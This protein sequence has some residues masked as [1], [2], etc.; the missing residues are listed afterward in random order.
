MKLVNSHILIGKL[1]EKY[2]RTTPKKVLYRPM[3]R[4]IIKYG[5]KKTEEG[6]IRF[7]SKKKKICLS[8]INLYLENTYAAGKPIKRF[9]TTEK[10]AIMTEL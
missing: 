1:N 7:Q 10:I 3:L 9:A 2:A 5:N 6:V 8:P 4:Y